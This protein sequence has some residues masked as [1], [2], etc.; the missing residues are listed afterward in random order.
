MTKL[1][2]SI[3]LSYP[4]CGNSWFRFCVEAISGRPTYPDSD[5][6]MDLR[7]N[8]NIKGTYVLRKEHGL[9][10]KDNIDKVP[11]VQDNNIFHKV[12][13]IFLLRN[14]KECLIRQNKDYNTVIIGKSKGP[15]NYME[16]IKE[17]DKWPDDKKLLIYYENLLTNPKNELLKCVNFLDLNEEKLDDFMSKFDFYKQK[18][19][20]VYDLKYG[21]ASKGKDLLY[22]SKMRKKEKMK[23]WDEEIEKHHPKMFEKY[24][25]RYIEV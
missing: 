13:L 10:D 23:V 8:L 7:N 24:L 21:S 3:L 12:K 1:N 19:I 4:R 20:E 11:V 25:K 18:S 5:Y 22:H 14:Y 17:F 9:Y 6:V 2:C 16:N 15:Y